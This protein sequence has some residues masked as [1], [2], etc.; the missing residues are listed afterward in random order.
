M[1]CTYDCASCSDRLAYAAILLGMVTS[2]MYHAWTALTIC[3]G[4][5]N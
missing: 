3:S 5:Y 4:H 2:Y 1:Q